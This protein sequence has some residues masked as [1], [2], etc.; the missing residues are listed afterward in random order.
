MYSLS[1]KYRRWLLGVWPAGPHSLRDTGPETQLRVRGE[2]RGGRTINLTSQ[3]LAL[4]RR[5]RHMT[6]DVCCL[7]NQRTSLKQEMHG[8]N[9]YASPHWCSLTTKQIAQRK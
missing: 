3:P 7:A 8:I 6:S 9:C 1:Q 4:P 2:G 5:S